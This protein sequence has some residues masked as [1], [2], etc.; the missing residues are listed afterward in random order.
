[1]LGAAR[2]GHLFLVPR[3]VIFVSG[4]LFPE[5]SETPVVVGL[6][7]CN[8]QEEVLDLRETFFRSH[9]GVGSHGG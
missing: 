8:G 6:I 2:L 4:H 7:L 5:F 3:H 9:I 1:M